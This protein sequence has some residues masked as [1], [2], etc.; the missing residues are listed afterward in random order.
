MNHVGQVV[1]ELLSYTHKHRDRLTEK[2]PVTFIKD[3]K[4]FH[5]FAGAR[6]WQVQ[7]ECNSLSFK[8][9]ILNI[10]PRLR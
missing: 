10:Y 3:Y 9:A 4:F 6:K 1:G 7:M 8:Q 2:H 5:V